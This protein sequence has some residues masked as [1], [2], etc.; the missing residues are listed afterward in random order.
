VGP[1]HGA[2]LT[3]LEIHA[4]LLCCAITPDGKT[5]VAGDHVDGLHVLDWRHGAE[6]NT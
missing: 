4:P 5:I 2:P 3:T 6:E 1:P